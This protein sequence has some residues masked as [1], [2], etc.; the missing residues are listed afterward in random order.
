MRSFSRPTSEQV[1]AAVSMLS[2]PHHERYF[3]EKLENPRWLAPLKERGFFDHPPKPEALEGGG[4]QYRVWPQSR[5][6]A[7]MAPLAP[8]EVTEILSQISTDN[9]LVV[10]DMVEAAKAMPTEPVVR[11][12]EA[13]GNRVEQWAANYMLIDVGELAAR[14]AREGQPE[15]AMRLAERTFGSAVRGRGGRS[16]RREEHAYFKGLREHVVPSLARAR[17][18]EFV[19]ALT[20]WM[21]A[22]MAHD[23][24]VGEATDESSYIWRPAIENHEQNRDFQFAAKL[25]SCLRDACETAI[26]EGGVSLGDI[27]GVITGADGQL[28]GRLRLHLVAEFKDQDPGLAR[29]A[30]MDRSLFTDY[31]F[32]HEYARLVGKAW[33]LL[34]AEEQE[35]WLEWIEEGPEGIRPDYYD[36]PEDEKRTQRQREYWQFQHLHWVR[37]HLVGEWQSFYDRMY[38]EHGEPEL[39][40]LNVYSGGVR[41]GRESPYS[42]EELKK[43]GFEQA[44]Q[45]VVRWRPAPDDRFDGP[46]VDGLAGC[47]QQFIENDAEAAS[48]Q[49]SLLKGAPAIYVRRFLESI[50]AGVKH[51]KLID[52]AAVIDLCEWVESRPVGERTSPDEPMGLIDADWQWCRDTIADLIEEISKAV[53]GDGRPSFGLE[54]RNALWRIAKPLLDSPAKLYVGRGDEEPGDPRVQDWALAM[55]NSTRGKAMRAVFEYAEWVTNHTVS[56]RQRAEAFPGGFDALPEVRA[57]LEEQLVRTDRDCAGHAAFGWFLWLMYWIDAGWLRARA[58][59]IFDLEAI[60]TNPSEAVGWAAWTVFLFAN[61]PHIEFYRLLCNQFSVAVDQAA[62]FTEPPVSREHPFLRLAEHL[63]VLYGRGDFGAA[64][65]QA[66]DTDNGIIRRLITETH[67]SVRS[68]AIQF[69]G[70]S[71]SKNDGELPTDVLKR[72]VDLWQLYWESVGQADAQADPGSAVFGYWFAA[73]VFDPKWAIERLEEFIQAAPNAEPDDLIVEQLAQ[74]CHIDPFRS[75][76]IIQMLINADSER[77]RVLGWKDDGKK[78]LRAAIAAGGDA[79]SVAHQAIDQLGRRG[80]LEFGDLLEA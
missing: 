27:L 47:F 13:I 39:A 71:L 61:R 6:L 80:F 12:I 26:R 20:T 52:L 34:Q 54:H 49:S 79:R 46:S 42:V 45:A 32:K 9:W 18:M 7:R 1:D 36:R 10:R 19:A 4:Y 57:C 22:A 25:V 78:V 76:R 24:E 28:F 33:P 21:S 30:V 65:R 51:G 68:H 16:L 59:E 60:E 55:L 37:E 11:L 77:W 67:S 50:T 62:E 35:Q 38:A 64:A 2:A 5:Y 44:V 69:V 75:A 66:W 63:I 43:L 3:F 15:A 74:V 53:D 41:H 48:S 23:D 31:R 58:D 56:R 72:F 8:D 73:G 70:M 14:L 40:D 17:P 29:R